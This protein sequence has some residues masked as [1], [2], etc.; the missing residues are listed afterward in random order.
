MAPGCPGMRLSTERRPVVPGES[1]AYKLG[2]SVRYYPRE[3]PSGLKNKSTRPVTAVHLASVD[4]WCEDGG[5]G[6]TTELN[7]TASG[8]GQRGLMPPHADRGKDNAGEAGHPMWFRDYGRSFC[9]ACNE[10]GIS[11]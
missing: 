2:S 7:R 9:P 3:Q 1:S 6:L 10:T 11:L 8:H 4:G 5:C